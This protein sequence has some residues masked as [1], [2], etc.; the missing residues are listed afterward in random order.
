[1]IRIFNFKKSCGILLF[2]FI[3]HTAFAMEGNTQPNSWQIDNFMR[4]HI[5]YLPGN[6]AQ[7][8]AKNNF[9]AATPVLQPSFAPDIDN[10]NL[11]KFLALGFDV[12]KPQKP[13][14]YNFYLKLYEFPQSMQSRDIIAKFFA[15][16]Q[17][18]KIP[19]FDKLQ[20]YAAN[21]NNL[22]IKQGYIEKTQNKFTAKN[23]IPA[24]LIAKDATFT[25]YFIDH[26][27][28]YS[29][30]LT[31][32]K[33]TNTS[34]P[35]LAAKNS[36]SGVINFYQNLLAS[37][38]INLQEIQGSDQNYFYFT[39]KNLDPKTQKI[40]I[41]KVPKQILIFANWRELPMPQDPK[42]IFLTSLLLVYKT[43]YELKPGATSPT[44]I[45]TI[46]SKAFNNIFGNGKTQIL[47]VGSVVY[48]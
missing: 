30:Y 14:T 39:Q 43:D 26:I 21:K 38:R 23:P 17:L 18:D 47:E 22:L 24:L 2:L 40:T 5:A 31:P 48:Y 16:Y 29:L 8:K 4:L 32:T 20:S 35:D 45:P 46:N 44:I 13:E 11:A 33:K 12:P 6:S 9:V 42:N 7:A 36:T 27:P 10:I 19:D 25:N 15:D 37:Y 34:S 41:L 28:F 1:M 3:C